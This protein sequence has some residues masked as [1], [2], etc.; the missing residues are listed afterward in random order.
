MNALN[1]ATVRIASENL[2]PEHEDYLTY[3]GGFIQV[4]C[5]PTLLQNFTDLPKDDMD[6]NLPNDHSQ[7]RRRQSTA[8]NSG[9]RPSVIFNSP[10]NQKHTKLTGSDGL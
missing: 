5:K 4:Q 1:E 3:S 7:I 2:V 10:Y 8:H 9:P 6:D